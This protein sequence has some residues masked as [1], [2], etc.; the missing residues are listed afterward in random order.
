[1]DKNS[2]YRE[3]NV[4]AAGMHIDEYSSFIWSRRNKINNYFMMH[5]IMQM[6]IN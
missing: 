3:V 5:V 6:P 2:L 1:M 4:C